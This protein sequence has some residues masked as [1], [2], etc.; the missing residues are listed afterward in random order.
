MK[1]I[2]GALV[3]NAVALVLCGVNMLAAPTIPDLESKIEREKDVTR[4][5]MTAKLLLKGG[6]STANGLRLS[7]ISL[8]IL[9]AGSAGLTGV[10]LLQ[11]RGS[12][13]QN[14]KRGGMP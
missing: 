3:L 5:R 9:A 11:H 6:Q 2:V 10:F 8:A 4:L 1:L 12:M 7:L 14:N 13:G